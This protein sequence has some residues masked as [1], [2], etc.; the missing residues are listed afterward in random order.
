M[1]D[2]VTQLENWYKEKARPFLAEY[3]QDK[4]PG[5]DEALSRIQSL[6]QSASE[7]L[8]IC[9]LGAEGVGKSTLINAL[10]AGAELVL[11]SGGIGPLTALAMEVCYGEVPA[12]EAEYYPASNLWRAIGF[13]LERGHAAALKSATGRE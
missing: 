5:L 1:S 12:F 7:E 3:L 11:P 4:V 10:V 2:H 6:N 13:P 8:A 9:F